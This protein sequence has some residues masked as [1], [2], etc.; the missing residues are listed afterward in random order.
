M[1]NE[2][3]ASWRLRLL[4]EQGV[5]LAL[6]VLGFGLCRAWIVS[7]LT[8][9]IFMPSAIGMNWLYLVMGA[10][11][12]LFVA[13]ASRRLAIESE[14]FRESIAETTVGL[15]ASVAV[16][17][18]SSVMLSSPLLMVTG[19]MV[20]GAAAGFLQILWG[21][22]F[23]VHENRFV[24]LASAA[25][26]IVTAGCLGLLDEQI[27]TLGYVAFPLL[28]FFLLTLEC[29]RNGVSWRTGL[30]L[31]D[32]EAPMAYPLCCARRKGEED[33]EEDEEH[34][35]LVLKLMASVAI[36]SFLVRM[37]DS[38]PDRGV[39]PFGAVGGSSLFALVVVGAV[40]IVIAFLPKERFN[41]TLVY[42]I[43]VPIMVMGL[44]AM[45]LFFERN[46]A[47]AIL[48]IGVGYE[49]FDIL[50]WILFADVSRRRGIGTGYIYGMGVA[51]MFLGMAA[52]ILAGD[53]VHSLIED[54]TLQVTV[55]GMASI[56]SLV[57][58]GFM[59]LPEGALASISPLLSN[60][61]KSR[62]DAEA[63][64][65]QPDGAPKADEVPVSLEDRCAAVA[66]ER[67]LTARESEIL[68]L[69]AKG[70]TI[71]I[72]ARDLQIAK[73]TARTHAERIYR[74]L[75]VHKQQELIDM[76][77]AAEPFASKDE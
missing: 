65:A 39:D 41:V 73:G 60:S 33:S 72:I 51:S 15:I 2:N 59:L 75:D 29:R 50:A 18:P 30:S 76:V 10:L 8:A 74:K 70:R 63:A 28:S 57:F 52:G 13:F 32:P 12:A 36:F 34:R 69:L 40:F 77:E 4:A 7:C 14:R 35:R 67:G 42:R 6:V 68:V 49:F 53:L 3:S 62:K 46:S 55:V 19:F 44:T 20:G 45:V 58:T 56:I 43:S 66:R 17:I 64:A 54:G 25:A 27:R 22:R 38:L 1:G 9:P 47:I 48:L 5:H 23:T 16:L 24:T 61:R 37:F 21:E 11:A 26:A 71:S 31:E